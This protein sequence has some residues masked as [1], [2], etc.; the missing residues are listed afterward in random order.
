MYEK[1][2][3]MFVDSDFQDKIR[4]SSRLDARPEDTVM[5]GVDQS[6]VQVEHQNLEI[7]K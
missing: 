1:S 5:V 4:R 3:R 7:F 6:L 2:D